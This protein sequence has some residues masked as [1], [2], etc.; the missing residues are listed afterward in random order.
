MRYDAA[1]KWICRCDCGTTRSVPGMG[2]RNGTSK[3]CGCLR[4][5]MTGRRFTKHGYTSGKINPTYVS[6]R[7]MIERCSDPSHPYYRY[8]GG[9]GIKVCSEWKQFVNFLRDMGERGKGTTLDRIDGTKGYFKGN[10]RWATSRQQHNNRCDTIFIEDGGKKQCLSDWEEE[11][12]I[13]RRTIY[14]R[15][16]SGWD[17]HDALTAEAKPQGW[18]FVKRFS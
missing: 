4:D 7:K 13:A 12:G 17:A 18:R 5:E 11:T 8:Y 6:W 1:K 9:H 14:T 2:L 10:C 3:S 16:Q 15:I